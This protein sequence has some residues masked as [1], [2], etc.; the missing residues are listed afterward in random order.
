[1][2]ADVDRSD[3]VVGIAVWIVVDYYLNTDS[4]VDSDFVD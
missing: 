4:A 3:V 2:L 1:M